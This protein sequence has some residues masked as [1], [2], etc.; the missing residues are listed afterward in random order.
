MSKYEFI[1]GKCYK[2]V[3]RPWR[4]VNGVKEYPKNAKVFT[5]LE[6]VPGCD[7]K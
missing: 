5:W 3:F 2:R 6:E 1:N 7:C 4:V